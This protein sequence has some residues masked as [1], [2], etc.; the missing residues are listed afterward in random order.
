MTDPVILRQPVSS[1]SQAMRE[2]AQDSQ[3]LS[4]NSTYYYALLA[5]HFQGTCLV[6]ETEGRVCGYVTG[7]CL[8]DQPDTL[9][10]WQVGVTRAWQGKGLGKKLLIGLINKKEPDFLEATIVLDNQASI[11]LFRSVAR[12]FSVGHT[13]AQ[14]PFFSKE[15]L[16]VGELAEHLMQVGPFK[17]KQ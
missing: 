16:G 13:F 1:D 6:A 12:Y 9:F 14:T 5:R 2:I 17:T 11:N 15:D 10:V 7:Y 8:P 3:V 4:V